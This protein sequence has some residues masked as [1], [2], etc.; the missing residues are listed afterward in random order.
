[1]VTEQWWRVDKSMEDAKWSWWRRDFIQNLD[2]SQILDTQSSNASYDLRA[3]NEY[4]DHRDSVKIELPDGD[5]I[6]L[7][8]GN[9]HYWD[10]RMIQFPKSRSYNP[11]VSLLQNGFIQY[12][13]KIDPGYNGHLLITVFIWVKE[14]FYLDKDKILRTLYGLSYP[15]KLFLIRKD[16]KESLET[17]GSF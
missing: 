11:K 4:R 3:G 15:R 13:I 2:T 16:I 17:L 8:P 12:C 7:Q 14:Q 6:C 1:M 10:N 9:S 5:K